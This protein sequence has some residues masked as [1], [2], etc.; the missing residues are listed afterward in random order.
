MTRKI[1][2]VPKFKP[3]ALGFCPTGPGG[4][5]DNSC[6]RGAGGQAADKATSGGGG[7]SRFDDKAF[8][9]KARKMVFKA[10]DNARANDGLV[11]G[12]EPMIGEE[13]M[14]QA[15]DMFDFDSEVS[16]HYNIDQDNDDDIEAGTEHITKLVQEWSDK[17]LGKYKGPI[18]KDKR[19]RNRKRG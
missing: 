14:L 15:N 1:K 17:N 5:I 12:E 4:G 8:T 11:A 6:G 9:D 2:V 10:L 3:L 18:G 19:T 16:E 7:K 13:A